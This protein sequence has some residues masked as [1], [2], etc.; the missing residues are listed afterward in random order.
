[1]LEILLKG[2]EDSKTEN[3]KSLKEIE[4]NK[5]YRHTNHRLVAICEK[6]KSD[7]VVKLTLTVLSF[8]L[9]LL[10]GQTGENW[11]CSYK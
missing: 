7:W 5:S 1:M 8:S 2:T 10:K 9:S 4:R 11:F 6:P 3:R